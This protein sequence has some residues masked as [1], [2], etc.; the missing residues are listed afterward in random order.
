MRLHASHH[1]Q[2]LPKQLR[3]HCLCSCEAG[4]PFIFRLGRHAGCAHCVLP[5]HAYDT[6]FLSVTA[7]YVIGLLWYAAIQADRL[8]P[9]IP[10]V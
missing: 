2:Q 7:Y 6:L 8:R 1:A 9:G 5:C 10:L 3:T 4:L